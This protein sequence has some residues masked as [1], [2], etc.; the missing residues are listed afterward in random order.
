VRLV[1]RSD[2]SDALA[3]ETLLDAT[4]EQ[5]PAMVTTRSQIAANQPIP[6][7]APAQC[8]LI[9][10]PTTSSPPR[11]GHVPYVCPAKS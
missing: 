7:P 2:N 11:C 6:L 8:G 4:L 9:N 3:H 5:A 1:E 10:S